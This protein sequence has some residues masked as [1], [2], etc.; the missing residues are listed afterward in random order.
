MVADLLPLVQKNMD[1]EVMEEFKERHAKMSGAQS[2]LQSGDLMGGYVWSPHMEGSCALMYRCYV[3]LLD[4]PSYCLQRTKRPRA[5]RP[6]LR[7]DL[8]L[9]ARSSVVARTRSD[10]HWRVYSCAGYRYM[11]LSHI[12]QE[13]Y[14]EAETTRSE[15]EDSA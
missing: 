5:L 7:K 10:R 9:R 13:V 3:P 1:P 8:V 2:A 11:L 14:N 6:E 15:H 4:S 12:F